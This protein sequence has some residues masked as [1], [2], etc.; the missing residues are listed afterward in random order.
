MKIIKHITQIGLNY[1]F[2]HPY[3]MPTIGGSG[4]GKTSWLLYLINH[5]PYIDKLYLHEKDPYER[6]YHFG[7]IIKVSQT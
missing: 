5:H 1:Y 7:I 2:D 6:K 4:S 3:R